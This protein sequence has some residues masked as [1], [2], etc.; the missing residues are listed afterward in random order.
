MQ[1][2]KVQKCLGTHEEN[3]GHKS[4]IQRANNALWLIS[5]FDVSYCYRLYG[6]FCVFWP[7]CGVV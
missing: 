1:T 3:F 7:T 5:H 6:P 4:F 2:F